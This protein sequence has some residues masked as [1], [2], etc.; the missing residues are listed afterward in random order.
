MEMATGWYR[1]GGGGGGGMETV[2]EGVRR[3]W[4][5]WHGEGDGSDM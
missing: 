1:E 4:W 2:M 3:G 5:Q